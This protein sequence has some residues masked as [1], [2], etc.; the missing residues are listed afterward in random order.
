[1]SS[2][3]AWDSSSEVANAVTVGYQTWGKVLTPDNWR[4]IREKVT[5]AEVNQ[6]ISD[7]FSA[8]PLLTAVRSKEK[9]AFMK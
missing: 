2:L 5:V 9:P 8:K 7:I 3:M 6:V 1:M 4:D